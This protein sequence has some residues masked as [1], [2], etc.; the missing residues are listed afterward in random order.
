MTVS[1]PPEL[2]SP[3]EREARAVELERRI[4]REWLRFAIADGLILVAAGAL[5][6]VAQSTD[7]IPG[8]L[9]LVAAIVGIPY[10][11]FV[12]YWVMK[13]IRPLQAE[14]GALRAHR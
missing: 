5:V 7:A 9:V 1:V 6:F 14:L 2:M 13:R 4:A 12:L 8:G 10:T 3:E 11:A